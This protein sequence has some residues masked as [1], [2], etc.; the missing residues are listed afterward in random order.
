MRSP[1]SLINEPSRASVPA[2]A[3][4]GEISI[5]DLKSLAQRGPDPLKA[6]VPDEMIRTALLIREVENT[7]LELFSQGKMNG[8]VH[9]CVGQEFAAV[10]VAGQLEMADWVTS[11]HRCHGHFIAKTGCWASLIDELMGLESGVC[12]GIGSSQHLFAQGF[13]SNG[14]QAALLPVASGI[15]HY[16]RR[17][18]IGAIAVSFIGEGTFGEGVLYETLNLA[19]I[20]QLPQL[21]VCENNLYSQS[22]PQRVAISGTI[23][24]R[25]AAFGIANFEA[26]TWD[27]KE[28]FATAKAAITYVRANSLPAMLTIRTYRLNAH[29][30]GDDD[31]LD[32]EIS[33]F[34]ERDP[35]HRL[36]Q[37]SR[38][39]AQRAHIHEEI[40][41][42]LET[43]SHGVVQI[44]TYVQD[45][46]PRRRSNEAH[47]LRNDKVR[48]VHALN[49]TYAELVSRGAMLVGED[50][51]DPYG[52]AFKVTKGIA[53]R[54]PDRVLTTPISE[55]GITGFCAGLALMGQQAYVEIMFGDF[56]TNIFDQL[57]NNIS[58]FHHMYAGQVSVPVRIRT[59]MGGKRG[60]GPTHSQSLEKFLVGIDNVA[61]LAVTSLEDPHQMVLEANELP[62]PVLIIENKI[63]Y[64]RTL[65][66]GC[67]DHRAEKIGGG[68]GT[69]VITPLRRKPTFTVVGYGETARELAERLKQIFLETDA[70]VELI[71]PLLLHPIDIEPIRRSTSCTGKL[72]VV[73]DGSVHAGI[74]SEIIASLV[75]TCT[76]VRCWRLG[77]DPVP[78][79]SVLKLERSV[80]PSADKVIALLMKIQSGEIA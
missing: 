41:H 62:G 79:P 61:V 59:P 9:T 53:E 74:G 15:A 36:L 52:G 69:I 55:A 31:R 50:V 20:W 22:T 13:L 68:L 25:A 71:V 45:Q 33:F 65:W 80:L 77:A 3:I 48:L 39:A 26:D 19:S 28:L 56:V 72:L 16:L 23:A 7:F 73:E 43:A 34:R 14:V 32:S 12:K 78:I 11:N 4:V 75:E 51:H 27:L 60:Y 37:D 42:H 10:A 76:D 57:I 1:T 64:G 47:E 38:W 17:V 2:D 29:S 66:Q 8:T 49:R 67:P 5:N 63:D 24:G 18:G 70:V 30:K 54:Y 21:I 6:C 40:R 46:L 35:L 44:S 58:K